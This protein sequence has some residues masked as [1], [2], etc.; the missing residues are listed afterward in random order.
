M[1]EKIGRFI[2]G[3]GRAMDLAFGKAE[4]SHIHVPRPSRVM[5]PDAEATPLELSELRDSAHAG[6]M[7]ATMRGANWGAMSSSAAC[8]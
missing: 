8:R 1:T 3:A 2:T 4:P 6:G 5:R 7:S